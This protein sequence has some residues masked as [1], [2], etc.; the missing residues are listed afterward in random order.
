[1]TLHGMAVDLHLPALERPPDVNKS[2]LDHHLLAEKRIVEGQFFFGLTKHY[3]K[4]S[5]LL[6]I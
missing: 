1:M 2:A 3:S 4:V 6:T 5:C